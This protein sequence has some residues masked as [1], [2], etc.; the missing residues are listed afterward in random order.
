V[1]H[2]LQAGHTR[3]KRKIAFTCETSE[4]DSY[5]ESCAEDGED[6]PDRDAACVDIGPGLKYNNDNNKGL[7]PSCG[8]LIQLF[9]EAAG[10]G[11][12]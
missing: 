12:S 4:A 6:F 10:L 2:E 5:P 8:T 7:R 9:N 3:A 11:R 1:A